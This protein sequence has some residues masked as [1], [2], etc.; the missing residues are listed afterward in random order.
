M[1][2]PYK[3]LI[4]IGGGTSI[5]QEIS[6]LGIDNYFT[7]GLNHVCRYYEPT[8]LLWLDHNFY[9]KN[10]DYINNKSS[11]TITKK[12]NNG[13]NPID[14]IKPKITEHIYK[15][16]DN[17][18]RIIEY[19]FVG[20]FALTLGID[21]GFKRIF[22]LGYDCCELNGKTHFHNYNK[23]SRKKH[24]RAY[25]QALKYY[26]RFF[27]VMPKDT[28][29]YNVSPKSKISVFSKLSYTGFL[30]KLNED[31]EIKQEEARLWL[32]GLLK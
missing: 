29:I 10:K 7:F 15:A 24:L 32:K 19:F 4:I 3:S 27:T 18:T 12:K 1:I 14:V 5:P 16:S 20:I 11:V 22:L 8:A 17:T 9:K 2:N 23:E 25:E 30:N 6:S 26:N 28:I 31:K 13:Q 21:L